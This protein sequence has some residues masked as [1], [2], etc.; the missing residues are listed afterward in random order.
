VIKDQL[1]TLFHAE[2]H[3][4]GEVQQVIRDVLAGY[5]STLSHAHQSLLDRYELRDVAI[6]VVGVGSV[7]TL[8][9]VLLL[10]AGEGDPCS[11]RSRR[12]ARRSWSRSQAPAPL[13]TTASAS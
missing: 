1:P 6:K 2:G 4:P 8:C 11:S 13:R 12:R 10:T 7:G 3:R 9:W 5:R